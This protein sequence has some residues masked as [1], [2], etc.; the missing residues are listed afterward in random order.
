MFKWAAF[1]ADAVVVLG[2]LYAIRRW[3]PFR[4]WF[5]LGYWFNAQAW[6]ARDHVFG[7]WRGPSCWT[8]VLPASV[9]RVFAIFLLAKVEPPPEEDGIEVSLDHQMSEAYKVIES[10]KRI[11]ARHERRGW[12]HHPHGC[13][14]PTCLRW[15]CQPNC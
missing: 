3:K 13:Y 4:W 6:G 12:N 8:R 15:C 7:A 10:W 9:C 1:A 5:T 14:D 2:A 11:S